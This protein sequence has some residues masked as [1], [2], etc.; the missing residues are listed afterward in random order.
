MWALLAVGFVALCLAITLAG[1]YRNDLRLAPAKVLA[2]AGFIALALQQGALDSTF[3][4]AILVGLGLSLIG[5][6][7]LIGTAPKWFLSGLAVFLLA[8]IAY[9]VAFAIVG[10]DAAVTGAAVALVAV[11]A[12]WFVGRPIFRAAPAP[13]RAPVALYIA[14]IVVMVLLAI[15]AAWQTQR[16]ILAVAA[17]VF[18]ASDVFVA[19]DQFM[20]RAWRNRAIGLPLYYAAQVML[21]FSV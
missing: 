14:T 21:A 18:A 5:D 15:G 12:L 1:S 2:S 6:A 13:M 20:A 10:F 9:I 11:P 16:P 4:N 3:G 8:H 19:R 7:L 17:I